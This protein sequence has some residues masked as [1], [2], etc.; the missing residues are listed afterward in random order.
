MF[1]KV[2]VV[3]NSGNMGKTTICESMLK[4]RIEGAEVVKVESLNYDGTEDEKLHARDFNLILKRIG[5]ADKVIVD[6]GASNIEE[7]ISQ[8]ESYEDSQEDI[9]FFIVPVIPMDKQQVDSVATVATLLDIGVNPERIK[10]IFNMADKIV[11]FERQFRIFLDGM[12]A[13]KKVKINS[14]SIIYHTNVFTMLTKMNKSFVEVSCD[15]R[16]FRSLI[17]QTESREERERLSEE[18]SVKRLVNGVNKDL[19]IAFANLEII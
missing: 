10:F 7:F 17:R 3:N 1:L 16:D 4:P 15:D 6:V 19:D 13:Y 18:Q 14:N 11:P 12:K 8:M 9:D 2:A 5:V